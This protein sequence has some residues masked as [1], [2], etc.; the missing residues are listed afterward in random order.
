MTD[1][2][3]SGESSSPISKKSTKSP[4]STSRRRSASKQSSGSS[5]RGRELENLIRSAS[6]RLAAQ[7][8]ARLFKW[9]IEMIVHERPTRCSSCGTYSSAGSIQRVG[10][11]GC[12]FFGFNRNGAHIAIEAKSI[13]K[14]SLKL[15]VE[16]G[17]GVKVHQM[18]HLREVCKAGGFGLIVWKRGS[19]IAILDAYPYEPGFA[20]SISANDVAWIALGDFYEQLECTLTA[21]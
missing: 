10:K 7:Q 14:P 4:A 19:D 5:N 8:V 21:S 17:D 12:D 13:D 20:K 3:S 6:Q 15:W 16:D 2:T 9:P 1:S 11:G 18:L